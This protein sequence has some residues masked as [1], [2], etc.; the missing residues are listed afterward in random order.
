[1]KL[2]D[3]VMQ[4]ALAVG[5]PDAPFTEPLMSGWTFTSDDWPQSTQASVDTVMAGVNALLDMVLRLAEAIDELRDTLD[6][7]GDIDP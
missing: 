3:E 2:R 1:M 4:R 7:E 6:M 5:D